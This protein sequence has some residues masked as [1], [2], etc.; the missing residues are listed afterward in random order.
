MDDMESTHGLH[1]ELWGG[2]GPSQY[3]LSTSS[4]PPSAQSLSA[5]NPHDGDRNISQQRATL[6][7]RSRRSRYGN[8]D[9][10]KYKP[11]LKKLYFDDRLSL[12]ETME[13]MQNTHSFQ[14]STKLY[15]DKFKEWKWQ[16]NL[17]SSHARFMDAKARKRLRQEGKSTVFHYGGQ[18]YTAE[19]AARTLSRTKRMP[20][21]PGDMEVETPPDVFYKTPANTTLDEASSPAGS[22]VSGCSSS[23]ETFSD[24]GAEPDQDNIP[25]LPSSGTARTPVLGLHL[26]WQGLTRTELLAM[27]NSAKSHV[28]QGDRSTA[29]S[30]LLK[31]VEGYRHILGATHQGS[32]KAGYALASFYAEDNRMVEADE[33]LEDVSQSF[34]AYLGPE[35]KSTYQHVLHTVELLNSWN[36]QD[37]GLAFLAQF[38]SLPRTGTGSVIPVHSAGGENT[39]SKGKDVDRGYPE[40]SGMSIPQLTTLVAADGSAASLDLALGVA[41][42][43]IAANDESVEILLQA[44]VNQSSRD[45][46]LVIQHFKA[47]ADLLRLYANLGKASERSEKF[48]EAHVVFWKFWWDLDWDREKFRSVECMEACM[49][50]AV[51]MLKGNFSVWAM[52]IFEKVEAQ[53]A[54]LFGTNDERY[55]WISISVG[56]VYQNHFSGSWEI[57]RGWF[58]NAC[59][60]A[61]STWSN[62]D[63]IVKSLQQA[64][65][66]GHFQ[67]LSDEGRPYKTVFGVS[68]VKITPLR[69][70][71]D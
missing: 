60:A 20:L 19:R 41:R 61:M 2:S 48:D 64:L 26:R 56:L 45:P 4:L 62:D 39:S 6:Q 71:L 32:V 28:L 9:W 30:L 52:E 8:L 63:G 68:G 44:I 34:L 5:D 1:V 37:D 59:S 35:H 46:D 31:V 65:E 7:T 47:R 38:R 13:V 23:Q 53:A 50:L 18:E 69:L 33:I 66:I 24:D 15:K 27:H 70:H 42:P 12:A 29:E 11:V 43:H 67:Y 54:L 21:G 25:T 36:R 57:A 51:S 3:N 10:D 16:K 22:I 40:S 17:P 14:A 55:V 49:Q 58:E